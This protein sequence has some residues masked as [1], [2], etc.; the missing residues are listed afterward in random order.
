MGEYITPTKFTLPIYPLKKPKSDMEEYITPT[1]FTLPICPLKKPK[2]DM[3]EY[4]TPTKFNLPIRP[5]KSQ[6]L[7][8]R[9]YHPYQIHFTNP[10]IKKAKIWYEG[11]HHPYQIQSFNPFIKK[12][13]NLKEWPVM[14]AASVLGP[15]ELQHVHWRQPPPPPTHPLRLQKGVESF[16]IPSTARHGCVTCLILEPVMF[17]ILEQVMCNVFNTWTSTVLSRIYIL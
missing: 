15:I 17:L 16:V 1:K 2:S 6:N 11:V 8:W 5:L 9:R 13:Q 10:S 3:E 4:I 12:A 7:I 14:F